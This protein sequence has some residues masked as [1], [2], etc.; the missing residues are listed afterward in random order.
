[1]RCDKTKGLLYKHI[2]VYI[3]KEWF[4]WGQEVR[5]IKLQSLIVGFMSSDEQIEQ[6]TETF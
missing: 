4:Q 1:M 6:S 5:V 3:S 2:T